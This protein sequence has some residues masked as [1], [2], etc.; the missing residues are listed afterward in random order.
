MPQLFNWLK[1]NPDKSSL[2][3]TTVMKNVKS[4]DEGLSVALRLLIHFQGDVHQPLH[5]GNRYTK[6]HT[7]G[8]RGG[9]DFIT[10]SHNKAKELHAVWDSVVFQNHK[11]PKRPFS[12]DSMNIFANQTN[13][14]FQGISVDAKDYESVDFSKFR[15]ESA[16][17]AQHVYEGLTEG[18][19]QA[20]P[21]SYIDKYHPIAVQRVALAAARIAYMIEQIYGAAKAPVWTKEDFPPLGQ[22]SFL[23]W[24]NRN[25]LMFLKY[26]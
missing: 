22:P 4:E 6:E 13:A 11:N 15:D 21:Q 16:A 2:A 5:I 20:V 7:A 23:Q 14:F 3:Y 24:M 10:K 12:S 9:N 8:D 25:M 26:S 17:I 19:D 1:G 18:K